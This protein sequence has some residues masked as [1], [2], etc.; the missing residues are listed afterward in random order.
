MG[1]C[2][3]PF[4]QTACALAAAMFLAVPAAGHAAS[5]DDPFEPFNRSMYFLHRG[6]DHYIFGPAARAYKAVLPKP[7]R[8][9]IRNVIDNLK[10]PAIAF[11]DLL[12][13]HPVRAGKTSARF[14][15][16][17]TVG[18]GGLMDI[19]YNIGIPHHDNG[20][21]E[22]AGRYNVA[23][24]PYLFI[25]F[26]GPSNF[27]DLLGFTADIVTDPLGWVRVGQLRGEVLYARP[28]LDGL[29]LR[30]ESDA[31]LKAIDD[32]STDPYAS[33]RSLYEQN[34]AL[35]IQEA[36]T[37]VPGSATP[38]FDELQD[39]GASPSAPAPAAPAVPAPAAPAQPAPAASAAP[40]ASPTAAIDRHV[41]ELLARPLRT[42][43]GEALE[44]A[45]AG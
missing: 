42:V 23:P 25:P 33:L 6:L 20:F 7:V 3:A 24:G 44:R 28:I 16:N 39:P 35:Q 14:V 32:M 34:R 1:S 4:K 40:E 29:D 38:S 30:A 13:A 41:E 37:G 12:Q 36:I 18:V 43:S 15:V 27:R 5:Y 9:G 17:S 31:Q 22:T 10:E 8:K 2:R 45:R 26:I 11:N 21:G 19:A